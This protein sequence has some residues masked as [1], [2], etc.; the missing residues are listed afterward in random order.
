MATAIADIPNL[1]SD[2][3]ETAILATGAHYGSVYEIYAHERVAAKTTDLTQK[4]IDD[5][6]AGKKP[7]GLSEAADVAYDMAKKL[8]HGRGGLEEGVWKKAVEKLGGK[9]GAQAVAQY[10]GLYAYTCVLL[11]ACDVPVPE[12]EKIK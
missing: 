12:G 8:V 3:R 11:N 4:Q 2:A 5:I 9:E 10:V 7:E 1:P 6:K